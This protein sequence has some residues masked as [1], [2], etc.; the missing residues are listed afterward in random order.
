MTCHKW[1]GSFEDRKGGRRLIEDRFKG[2]PFENLW[3]GSN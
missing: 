1:S 2:I 3:L